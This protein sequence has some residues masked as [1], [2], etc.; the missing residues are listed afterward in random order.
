MTNTLACWAHSWV[1]EEIEIE[2]GLTKPL[3]VLLFLYRSL[4]ASLIDLCRSLWVSIG[5]IGLYWSYR[6]LLVLYSSI[7]PIGL[8]WSYRPLLVL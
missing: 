7:G 5:P 4:W 8:Y 1:T 6:P 2:T 3:Q